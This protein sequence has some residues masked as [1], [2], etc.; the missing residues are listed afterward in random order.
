MKKP[1][2]CFEIS[3]QTDVSHICITNYVCA[4]KNADDPST[5]FYYID[6]PSGTC[7]LLTELLAI[8]L[9]NLTELAIIGDVT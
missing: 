5:F 2:K 6:A 7:R 9:T 4:H 3:L 8:E 1:E